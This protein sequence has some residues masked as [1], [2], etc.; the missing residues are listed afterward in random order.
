MN[1][2]RTLNEEQLLVNQVKSI[3]DTKIQYIDYQ[4]NQIVSAIIGTDLPNVP[5]PNVDPKDV[6][7]FNFSHNNC[8]SFLTLM[9]EYSKTKRLLLTLRQETLSSNSGFILDLLSENRFLV[10]TDVELESMI[11]NLSK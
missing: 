10:Y 3:I 8:D 6:S 4:T 2:W 9:E 1:S 5:K 7:S 11:R